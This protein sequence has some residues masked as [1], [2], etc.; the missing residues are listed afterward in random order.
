MD[1]TPYD[2]QEGEGGFTNGA[3][4]DAKTLMAAQSIRSDSGRHKQALGALKYKA[5]QATGAVTH[6]GGK[7]SFHK[8]V[9]A[10]MN[11]AFGKKGGAPFEKAAENQDTPF[12]EAESGE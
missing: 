6:E 11:K 7:G 5:D 2:E 9:K 4:S 3:H 8:K 1:H 12:T 10:G